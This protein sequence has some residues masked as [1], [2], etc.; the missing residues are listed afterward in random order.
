MAAVG[1]VSGV[2]QPLL[3]ARADRT[4]SGATK[5][6]ALAVTAPACLLLCVIWL[7][8][9][10]VILRVILYGVAWMLL[11]TLQFLISAFG[12]EHAAAG[13][14][15]D[16]GP[17]RAAGSLGY[18]LLSYGLGLL[19]GKLGTEITLPYAAIMS[20]LLL[21][22]LIF[23]KS[24]PSA[25]RC[26]EDGEIS[27]APAEKGFFSRYPRF[28]VFVAGA[29]IAMVAYCM[30]CNFLV[31]IVENLGGGSGELGTAVMIAALCEIPTIF[32]SGKLRKRFGSGRL[33]KFTAGMLFVKALLIYLSDSMGFLYGA[34]VAQLVS[35]SLFVP[36]SVYYA[37]A[38]MAPGDRVRGQAM[39]TLVTT[40]GTSIGS[41]LGGTLLE[42]GGVHGMLVFCVFC[43]LGGAVVMIAGTERVR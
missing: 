43:S 42:A 36:V 26:G 21:I 3:A 41:L 29:L 39:M 2:M 22:S 15:V 20:G 9:A 12:M 14:K 30:C 24:A 16:F 37:D 19:A 33:M 38:R 32:L 31:R 28:A 25:V 13:L 7:M 1:L 18:A 23:W 35:Y 40:L 8:P 5:K 17:C 34:M 10:Y 6:L 4:G 27:K 11:M